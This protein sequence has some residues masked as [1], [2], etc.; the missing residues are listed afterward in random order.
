VEDA[1]ELIELDAEHGSERSLRKLSGL[2]WGMGYLESG[3]LVVS[4]DNPGAPMQWQ[5]RQHRQSGSVAALTRS[6]NG[7]QGVQLTADR[8]T[9]VATQTTFSRSIALGAIAGGTFTEVVAD[10]G[11]PGAFAALD[12][13]GR[14]FYTARV[15]SGFA[16]FRRDTNGNT[17]QLAAGLG[18]A[19][20][21]PD[22]GFVVG[23]EFARGLVRVN[24]DGSGSAVLLAEA[25]ARPTA[26]T[27]DGASVIY[28]SNR[29]G[30]QQPWLLPLAGGDPR[31]LSD[32]YIGAAQLWLAA[33]GREAI[34]STSAGTRLCAF[35]SFDPCRT[36][37]LAAGPLS[38]D[39]KTVFAVDP[40]DPRNL[41]AQPIDGGAP[42]PLTRFTDKEIADFSLSPDRTQ[43]A[44]TRVSRVSDVVLIK[45][46]K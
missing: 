25:T 33:D 35:P 39:G 28:I 5:W 16:T 31:R 10:S 37:K 2:V 3:D 17:A 11:S 34:F 45:G 44:I 4:A 30:P 7:F 14:L 20:P 6:L 29:S 15:A 13:R 21:S 40:N 22:A 9:G 24:P 43:V 18:M 26:F 19:I 41:L 23:L 8:T 27:P 42:M 36:L 46:L 12:A 38:T 1:G 32:V